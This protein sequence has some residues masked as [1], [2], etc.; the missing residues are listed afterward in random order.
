MTQSP[1]IW[2]HQAFTGPPPGSDCSQTLRPQ[3]SALWVTWPSHCGTKE[4]KTCLSQTG[5]SWRDMWGLS[6]KG[7]F[8]LPTESG[9]V[10]P[11]WL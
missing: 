7:S 4:R 8:F 6:F 11:R 5:W 1:D 10:G 9:G 3:I 2:I